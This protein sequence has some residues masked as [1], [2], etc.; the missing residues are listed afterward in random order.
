MA[1]IGDTLSELIEAKASAIYEMERAIFTRR[2]NLSKKHADIFSTYSIPMLYS[3]WEGFVTQAFREYICCLNDLS[4]G[5]KNFC[6]GIALLHVNKTLSLD[7]YPSEQKSQLK[8]IEKLRCFF[9]TDD[10]RIAVDTADSIKKGNVN[11]DVLNTMLGVFSLEKFPQHWKDTYKHPNPNL[12][13]T[14]DTFLKMRNIVAH[15]G[16]IS[17]EET[18]TQIVFQR[19]KNLVTDLMDEIRNKM[20]NGWETESYKKADQA[21]S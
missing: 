10:H 1:N 17:S 15:G 3:I 20:I 2:Y 21:A 18:V 5:Y 7:K 13:E 19:Y 12:K 6:D 8:F 11:L 14:L 16:D 9:Q 4:I